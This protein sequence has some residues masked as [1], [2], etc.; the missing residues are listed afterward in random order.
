M[1]RDIIELLGMDAA[2]KKGKYIFRENPELRIYFF[3]SNRG[4]T[5]KLLKFLDAHAGSSGIVFFYSKAALDNVYDFL[6][7][8]GYSVARYYSDLGGLAGGETVKDAEY[9]AFVETGEKKIMLATS[10]F[11]MGVDKKDIRFVIHYD[12]PPSIENYYQ[13]IGRAGR[14]GLPAEC[15]MFCGVSENGEINAMFSS[16]ENTAGVSLPGGIFTDE[17]LA[18]ITAR[19]EK[20]ADEM[21]RLCLEYMRRSFTD[22]SG[23]V[24]LHEKIAEYFKTYNVD[25][26]REL[27]AIDRRIVRRIDNLY[28]NRT[29]LARE[30]REYE[31]KAADAVPENSGRAIH[32]D[33]DLKHKGRRASGK[34][35]CDLSEPLSYFDA[36]I[37]DAVYT[38]ESYRV[39]TIYARNVAAVL[40]GDPDIVL[41]PARKK[42]IE[43]ALERMSR[44]SI[45]IRYD[46]DDGFCYTEEE[47]TG[48]ISG[49]FLPLERNPSGGFSWSEKPP[50]GRYAEIMNGEFFLIPEGLLCVH[51]SRGGKLPASRENLILA[52]CINTRLRMLRAPS[53]RKGSSGVS[54]RIRYDYLFERVFGAN[55]DFGTRE[56]NRRMRVLREKKRIILSHICSRSESRLNDFEEYGGDKP[57]GVML[58]LKSGIFS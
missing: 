5:L 49:P 11:G 42:E 25:L 50:L 16:K 40:S 32:F 58:S 19:A 27:I 4:R 46:P 56:R 21:G 13:E 33:V 9:R 55:N 51:V 48:R 17:E 52:Y 8:K 22:H 1:Q 34:V 57:V 36:M 20:R 12:V 35:S 28:A 18:I 3:K 23:S 38:L 39:K 31:I 29:A 10:A 2:V 41:K 53:G 6:K 37:A 14:D 54:R 44:V 45:S 43:E 15:L 7:K 30:I 24:W 47:R 26:S